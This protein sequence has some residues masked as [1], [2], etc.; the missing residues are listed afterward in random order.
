MST[1]ASLIMKFYADMDDLNKGIDGA[2]GK[3]GSFSAGVTKVAGAA[4]LALG[5]GMG[6]AA[7]FFVSDL[8]H[9]L[10]FINIYLPS[11]KILPIFLLLSINR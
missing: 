4:A 2:E 11:W 9:Q 10:N 6:A 1:V 3:I 5:A 7:G 8:S